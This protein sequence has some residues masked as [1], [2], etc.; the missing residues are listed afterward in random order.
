MENREKDTGYPSMCIIYPWFFAKICLHRE[1]TFFEYCSI[2][3]NTVQYFWILHNTFEYCTILAL[4]AI[5]DEFFK[6]IGFNP[7]VCPFVRIGSP[8]PPS[9]NRVFPTVGTN[10]GGGEATLACGWGSGGASSNGWRENLYFLCPTK[11][12]RIE[13]C[14]FLTVKLAR[15]F[16]SD[17]DFEERQ[18][19]IAPS[20]SPVHS[21]SLWECFRSACSWFIMMVYTL[22]DE[23]R[24]YQN[25]NN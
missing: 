13:K 17:S 23:R 22:F 9:R 16:I 8:P 24:F 12:K 19:R 4:A 14:V 6:Q 1:R 3:L 21:W 10:K 18:T 11:W 5:S 7:S 2:L 25:S 20:P 15:R